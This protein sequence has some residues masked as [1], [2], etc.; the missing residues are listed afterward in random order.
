MRLARIGS[1]NAPPTA[2]IVRIAP[3]PAGEGTRVSFEGSGRDDDGEVNEYEWV[4]DIDG[5]LSDNKEFSR[6][7]LSVG[8]HRISFRVKDNGGAWS[9]AETTTLEIT[10]GSQPPWATIVQIDPS[11]AFEGVSVSFKGDAGDPDGDVVGYR[12]TSDRDG[13]L[14]D[15]KNFSTASLSLGEHGISFEA[16][17]DGGMWSAKATDILQIDPTPNVRPNAVILEVEPNPGV[18]GEAIRFRGTGSDSDGGGGRVPLAIEY[19]RTPLHREGVRFIRAVRRRPPH[20]ASRQ[21]TTTMR[22]RRTRSFH[23]ISIPA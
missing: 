16:R 5:H 1:G 17:D 23:S 19:R 10:P 9:P 8:A 18:E 11:P 13:V 7:R 22:G 12:W 6:S 4:S 21:G 14:S 3:N 15:R 2:T 20:Q